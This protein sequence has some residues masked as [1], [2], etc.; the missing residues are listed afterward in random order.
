MH[1]AP[2]GDEDVVA[3]LRAAA[4][5]A[6]RRGAPATSAA[7]LTRALAEP[8]PNTLR[9]IVLLELGRDEYTS[10]RIPLAAEHLEAAHRSAVDPSI[11][12]F[13]LLSLFQAKAGNFA[14]Q[15]AL[16]P[17]FE[18]TLPEALAQNRELGL[19][20]W[21]VKLLTIQPGPAWHEAA[22]GVDELECATPG[23]AI[24]IGHSALPITRRGTTGPQLAAAAERAALHADPLLEEGATALVMTGIVLG[25]VWAD[26]LET[27]ERLLGRA[28]DTARRRGSV[29][30]FSLAHNFRATVH[31]RAG[32]LRDAEADAQTALAA[33]TGEG[34]AGAGIGALSP[35]IAS[36]VDQGRIDDAARELATFL[37]TGE[38]SDTPALNPLLYQ[39]MRLRTAQGDAPRAR[40]DYAEARRRIDLHFSGIDP[41][42]VPFL[43]DAAKSFHVFGEL[44]Q[45][46]AVLNEA[47][48]LAAHWDLPGYVGQARHV[49]ARLAGGNDAVNELVSSIQLLRGSPSRLELAR[50]LITLGEVLRR[51][52]RRTDSRE[53]LREGYELARQCGAETLAE[54]ARTELRASGIRLRREAVSGVDSL[55]ASE[56]RIAEL[57]AGGASNPE[58][59]QALFLTIKTVEG[60]LTS[61]YRKL[62][63]SGR[64]GLADTLTRETSGSGQGSSP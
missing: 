51:R 2:A 57:A 11:R 33:A 52:G 37:P 59:A 7:L 29:A 63:I 43:L 20:L 12:G 10:G 61:T 19:R 27:A 44:A 39:R 17:L 6:R 64:S 50:A 41:S 54:T 62:D 24:L 30:D 1:T 40:A 36:L 49:A 60:H 53:P 47:M 34:W 35:L 5:L 58:I 9:P 18:R 14:A 23:E 21:A 56:R 16:E 22:R 26:R 48:E 38:I 31:H 15:R 13:A 25:L 3:E 4:D 32:R 55:T 45:R 46:N 8:P 28:I 42:W